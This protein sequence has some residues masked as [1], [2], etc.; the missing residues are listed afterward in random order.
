MNIGIV[1]RADNTVPFDAGLDPAVKTHII[2]HLVETGH[3]LEHA[4][5]GSHVKL[6]SG[7][8]FKDQP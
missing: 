5:D 6:L 2:G 4:H 3:L 1:I 7:P 8:H